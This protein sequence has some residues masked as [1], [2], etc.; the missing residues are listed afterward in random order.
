MRLG[1]RPTCSR[2]VAITAVLLFSIPAAFI[3]IYIGWHDPNMYNLT[4]TNELVHDVEHMMFFGISVLFWWH[5]TGDYRA[6]RVFGAALSAVTWLRIVTFAYY[7]GFDRA[8]G[9]ALNVII[10]VFAQGFV[11]RRLP[12]ARRG[13]R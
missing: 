5:V 13:H 2:V 4:L 8:A 12:I 1:G 10:L 9:I 3:I 7:D 11:A 6:V